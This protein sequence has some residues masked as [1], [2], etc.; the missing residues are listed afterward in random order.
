MVETFDHIEEADDALNRLER[1]KKRRG[2]RDP[3]PIERH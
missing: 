2:Y 1:A 3:N